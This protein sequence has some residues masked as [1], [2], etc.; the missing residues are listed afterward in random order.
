MVTHVLRDLSEAQRVGQR[1]PTEPV[2]Q[3]GRG[4]IQ[5]LRATTKRSA[6][7]AVK[8]FAAGTAVSED[9]NKPANVNKPT[10]V[11]T[12]ASSGLGLHGA[13][14]LAKSALL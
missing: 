7:T 3:S 12:G 8:T 4:A 1:L 5:G 10:V 14:K 2:I 6:R 11:V 9:P 13:E